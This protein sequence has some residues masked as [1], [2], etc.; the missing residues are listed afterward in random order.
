MVEKKFK[1]K[2]IVH[3]SKH[4]PDAKIY[5]FGS[6]ATG[7]HHDASDIDIAIDCGHRADRHAMAMI[8][9]DLEDLNIPFLVDIVDF[10]DPLTK[11]FKEEIERDKIIWKN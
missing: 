1:N 4:L 6:R 10:Q 7:E 3:I 9:L 2:L 8:R 5:L 11:S